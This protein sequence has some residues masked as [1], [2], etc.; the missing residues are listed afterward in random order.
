MLDLHSLGS[1]SV[2]NAC[3]GCPPE[4]IVKTPDVLSPYVYT[5][6]YISWEGKTFSL[7]HSNIKIHICDRIN[8]NEWDVANIDFELQLQNVINYCVLYRLKNQ[9]IAIIFATM[10]SDFNGVQTKWYSIINP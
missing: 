5:E 6:F 9:R 2:I 1:Q 3:K 7:N 8:G 10:M 4:V